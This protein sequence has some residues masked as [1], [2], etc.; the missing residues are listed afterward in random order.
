M[1]KHSHNSTQ[2]AVLSG[3]CKP[4][5]HVAAAHSLAAVC[6]GPAVGHGQD[7]PLAML[8]HITDLVRELSIG[9]SIDAFSTLS[10]ACRITCTPVAKPSIQKLRANKGMLIASSAMMA[11]QQQSLVSVSSLFLCKLLVHDMKRKTETRAAHRWYIWR[12]A[13]QVFYR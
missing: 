10:R 9:S 12:K 13:S 5:Q 7:A 4:L 2:A 1:I 8:Q 6:V 11:R 3:S